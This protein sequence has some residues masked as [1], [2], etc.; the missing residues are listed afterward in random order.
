MTNRKIINS[1]CKD[2]R[3]VLTTLLRV[4]KD[5]PV[6]EHLVIMFSPNML[7]LISDNE[8]F[9]ERTIDIFHEPKALDMAI[10]K[11]FPRMNIVGGRIPRNVIEE[12]REANADILKTCGF[13][14]EEPKETTSTVVPDDRTNML[15]AGVGIGATVMG[16]IAALISSKK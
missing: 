1:A 2:G 12:F 4:D 14:D 6:T 7:T 8:Y 11:I 10:A 16:V 5:A 13:Y 9:G 15:V 3:I